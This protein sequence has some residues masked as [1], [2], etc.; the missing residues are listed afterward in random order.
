MSQTLQPTSYTVSLAKSL[1][2]DEM[3][4]LHRQALTEAE[5]KKTELKL[6]LASRYRELV[7]SSDEVLDMQRDAKVL[8]ELISSIPGLVEEL[9][10]CA[11]GNDESKHDNGDGELSDAAVD[12]DLV[13]SLQLADAPRIIHSCLDADDVHGAA[14]SIIQTF[15]LITKYTRQYPLANAL[16]R[17]PEDGTFTP[18][19]NAALLTQIKMIYLHLQSIPLRTLQISK[20]IL[21]DLSQNCSTT[22]RALSALHLLNVQHIPEAQRANKLMDLYFDSKAKLIHTLLDRLSPEAQGGSSNS[23]RSKKVAT[24]YTEEAMDAAEK[25]I[26]EILL[27]L[28]Y[29]IILYPCQIFMIRKYTKEA[30]GE[31][32]VQSLPEFDS[33]QLKAKVSNFLAAHLPLIRS[34]VKTI[35]V[36]IAGTT[37]SRLGHMRQSLYDKTDGVECL[38]KLSSGICTWDDAVQLIDVKVVMRALEGLTTT[39][40]TTSAN[41]SMPNQQRSFSLWGT[42]FSNTFSSLV[43]SILSTSF[44][45]VHRQVVAALRGSLANAPPFREILPHEAYRNTLHIATELDKALKKVSDDA[46]ELLVHAEEREES[47]RRL[48]QSLYVQTCEIM[49]RLLNELRR[50]LDKSSAKEYGRDEDGDD[51]TKGLIVGRLCFLLKFRLTSLPTLL[52]PNSSPAVIASKSGGKVGMITIV[53]LKSAFDIAD[54]DDDSLVTYEESM[55]AMEGAFSGTH[56]HGAEMVRDTMLLSSGSD[57]VDLNSSGAS[58]TL[59]LSELALLSA[60]GL[61]HK[62]KGPESALGTIQRMLD[63]IV[64]SCFTKWASVALS[65]SLRK[66]MSG[67]EQ[68]ID[69]AS[70]VTES[71]WKRLHIMSSISEED[72]L[73]QEIGDALD[74]DDKDAKASGKEVIEVGS[75]SSFLITYFISITAV[76]NQSISPADS[77]QPY[78]SHSYATA[79]GIESPSADDTM[80]K[81]L[82]SCLVRESLHSLSLSMY[83]ELFR[84]RDDDVN[85]EESKLGK[86]G[87]SSLTQLLLDH[88]FVYACY[89]KRNHYDFGGDKLVRVSKEEEDDESQLITIAQQSKHLLNEIEETSKQ[90]LRAKPGINFD[91]CLSTIE[92]RHHA[93]FTSCSMF[94]M[95]LFGEEKKRSQTAIAGDLDAFSSLSSSN[96]CSLLVAPL[97]SSRRFMLLPIQAEQSVKE[98]QLI[99]NLEKERSDKAEAEKTKSASSAAANA[100]SS[101][102]GFFSS[103]LNK[104]K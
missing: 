95:S 93:A 12:S 49:C 33:H 75:V 47:E 50:M 100:V 77:I 15:T 19:M 21:L 99:K 36:G 73:Q 9:I 90:A 80:V 10:E 60:R 61:R 104:K 71:E 67:V 7:G 42:L 87:A 86:F 70:M 43:H 24:Y 39:A 72:L 92:T 63:N 85:M 52:N 26:S 44:H 88:A 45:S 103:M 13:D 40:P 79:M 32:V 16:S 8:D 59:T 22:A 82:R 89:F 27:I 64:E 68:F 46:H 17:V 23:A 83:N 18:S 38:E 41:A 78:P 94:F 97:A 81:L 62:E 51:A 57:G 91:D 31:N 58:L 102:F 28:Q 5:A 69:T 48:K 65:P 29:D 74:E 53:E 84:N 30:D 2:I 76:L 54:I 11:N 66:C 20:K 4:A 3:R 14:S 6:V 37:A 98:L 34:K 25:T 55:E 96:E 1:T 101:S 35:L 56:F